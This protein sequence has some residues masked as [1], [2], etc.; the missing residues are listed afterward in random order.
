[1]TNDWNT[2]IIEEFRSKSGK[3]GG[4]FAGADL[5]LRTTTGRKSGQPHTTPAMYLREGDTIYVFA[6]KGGGP[7]NPDW[8]HNLT[9]NPTVQVELGN[10]S[11]TADAVVV[12][13]E[14]RDRIY[15]KQAERRPQFAEYQQKTTRKIPVVALT[16][17][18]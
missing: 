14:E 6:S 2:R 18:D 15:A 4:P 10:A 9:A 5:L 11:F 7:T 8:F 1:M 17:R 16:R 12:S 13:G 3:V